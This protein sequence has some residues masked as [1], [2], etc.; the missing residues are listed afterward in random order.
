MYRLI[1]YLA[2]LSAI[3]LLTACN[4]SGPTT[5]TPGPELSPGADPAMAS[6]YLDTLPPLGVYHL[7]GD[8]SAGT[9][10]LTPITRTSSALAD[11]FGVDITALSGVN[12]R[13]TGVEFPDPQTVRLNFSFTHPLPSTATR[14]DLHVFD[15]RVHFLSPTVS[16]AYSGPAGLTAPIGPAGAPEDIKVANA[17][18]KAADGWST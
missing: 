14:T 9:L 4:Q 16:K 6:S 18:L 8:P 2:A 3:G 10:A 15:L 7:T 5:I 17:N 13:L 11:T 1:P 12:F